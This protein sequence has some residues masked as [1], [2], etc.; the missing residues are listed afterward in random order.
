VKN[1]QYWFSTANDGFVLAY[2]KHHWNG[3]N[4]FKQEQKN[5]FTIAWTVRGDIKPAA[6]VASK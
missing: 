1:L 3:E 6:K 4:A 2:S 5:G